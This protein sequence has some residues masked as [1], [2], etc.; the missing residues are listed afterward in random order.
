MSE[1]RIK[2]TSRTG[3]GIVSP[4]G[5]MWTTEIFQTEEEAGD[6]IKRFWAGVKNAPELSKFRIV[7][8]KTTTS[9]LLSQEPSHER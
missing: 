2:S 5:Q 6:Y 3:W 8:A 9:A 1:K 7:R 4:Y